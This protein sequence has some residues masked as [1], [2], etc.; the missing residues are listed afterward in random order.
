MR[1]DPIALADK[2][3]RA[4]AGLAL[5]LSGGAMFAQVIAR[6]GFDAPF[7]WAEEFATLMFS[8]VIFLGA[9]AVQRSDSHLSVDTLRGRLG[10]RGRL[11]LDVFRRLVIIACSLVLLWQGAALSMRMW[12]LAYPAMEISRSWLYLTAPVGAVFTILFAA[13][14]LWLREPPGDQVA[15]DSADAHA[16]TGTRGQR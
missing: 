6:Y 16:A 4:T 8:W 7:V 12:S 3:L 11:G 13:R 5:A 1:P 10:E 14:S 2:A 15:A 9:A